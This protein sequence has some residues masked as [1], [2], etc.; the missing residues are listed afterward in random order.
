[1]FRINRRLYRSHPG[2][3]SFLPLPTIRSFAGLPPIYR[4]PSGARRY[5]SLSVVF[6]DHS[7]ARP[8]ATAFTSPLPSPPPVGRSPRRSDLTDKKKKARRNFFIDSTVEAYFS[9]FFSPHSLSPTPQSGGGGGGVV[10]VFSSPTT[11]FPSLV[12][13]RRSHRVQTP[14]F[15]IPFGDGCSRRGLGRGMQGEKPASRARPGGHSANHLSKQDRLFYPRE[16]IFIFFLFF[17]RVHART[18]LRAF[19]SVF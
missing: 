8:T 6:P 5:P 16:F 14:R 1:M 10:P 13:L 9:L 19:F 15:F 12:A 11:L 7:P 17:P 18:R 2:S 3:V 4:S